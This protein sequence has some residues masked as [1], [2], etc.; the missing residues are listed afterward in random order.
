MLRR[1]YARCCV[2]C[3]P[4]CSA[5]RMSV[6]GSRRVLTE[7]GRIVWYVL[8]VL[9]DRWRPFIN[10]S[11]RFQQFY[12][13]RPHKNR[14]PCLELGRLAK[15]APGAPTSDTE[16]SVRRRAA[17]GRGGKGT[18][19]RA[20]AG[21]GGRA[22]SHVVEDATVRRRGRRLPGLDGLG[23]AASLAEEAADSPGR[24]Q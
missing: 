22:G 7:A 3:A 1:L 8:D 6:L 13:T 14:T 20:G 19:R 21:S 24:R 11:M 12:Q 4:L 5:A 10:G 23:G 9:K 17:P 15:A 18:L 16:A 2:A